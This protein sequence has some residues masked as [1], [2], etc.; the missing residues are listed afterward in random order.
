MVALVV[1]LMFIIL[2]LDRPRRGIIE[3]S[4]QPILDV[5]A[6][7]DGAEGGVTVGEPVG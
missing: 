1:L 7:I 3:V 5:K 2:D 6:Q 4:V